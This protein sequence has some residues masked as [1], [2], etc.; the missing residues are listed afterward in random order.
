MY[1]ENED[2]DLSEDRN[3]LEGGEKRNPRLIA[4][5]LQVRP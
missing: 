1:P 3:S 5:M 4:E 2:G